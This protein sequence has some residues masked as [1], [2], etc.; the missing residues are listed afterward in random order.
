MNEISLETI[1]SIIDLCKYSEIDGEKAELV[2]S[3]SDNDSRNI[4]IGINGGFSRE[5]FEYSYQDG[6]KFDKEILPLIVNH[7]LKGEKISSWVTND[8]KIEDLPT[9][10]LPTSANCA[11]NG[12]FSSS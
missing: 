2:V 7:F 12:I 3:P 1:Y 6:A 8:P 10:G 5:F 4:R 11:V 9:L